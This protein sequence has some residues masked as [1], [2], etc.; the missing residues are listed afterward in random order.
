MITQERLKEL[1]NYDPETGWFTNRQ[2]RGRAKQGEHAGSPTSHVQGYRRIVIDYRPYYEHHLAWF[3]VYGEW[4]E[5]IDH[6]NTD[7][8]NNSIINLR[9]CNR[10]Q[11]NCN[12]FQRSD[13]D[14]G[15]RGAYLDKR[16]L[17]WYS[18][19][20]FGS[21]IEWLGTFASAEEAH[22]A[23][24]AAAERLHGEFYSPPRNPSE[25]PTWQS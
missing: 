4:L 3:Y 5:E 2:S 18:K 12:R 15:L 1:F 16:N 14:A 20:Q 21:Q 19:I 7:G 10:T 23:F 6:E 25:E 24:E 22:L 17:Q 11:N 13:G 9:P 8:G